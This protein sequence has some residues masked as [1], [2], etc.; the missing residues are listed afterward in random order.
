MQQSHYRNDE[1]HYWGDEDS[2]VVDSLNIKRVS[3][4]GPN[5]FK[6]SWGNE[7]YFLYPALIE[8]EHD[9]RDSN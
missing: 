4:L 6:V 9:K 1:H 3:H 5:F 7:V 8:I 2:S